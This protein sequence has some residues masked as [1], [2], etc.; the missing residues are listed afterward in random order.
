MVFNWRELPPT[1]GQIIDITRKC[2]ALGIRL[3][4]EELPRN[5]MEARN[6]QYELGGKLRAKGRLKK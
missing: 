2:I 6:R 5:R 4:L 1:P 3:P